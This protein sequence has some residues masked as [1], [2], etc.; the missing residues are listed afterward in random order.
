MDEGVPGSGGASEKRRHERRQEIGFRLVL[1]I[2][3]Q[4]VDERSEGCT[5]RSRYRTPG[6][7]AECRGEV[8]G[9]GFKFVSNAAMGSPGF[10]CGPGKTSSPSDS[11]I[12]KKKRA[13]YAGQVGRLSS[14]GEKS[15]RA[16]RDK[17]DGRRRQGGGRKR[18]SD[19]L[20][21]CESGERRAVPLYKPM[22]IL[23]YIGFG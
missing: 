21:K 13:G 6:K 7:A 19:G 1:Q 22:R 3:R 16:M 9:C 23:L 14:P 12:R 5:I 10:C 17:W 8:D 20:D 18:R 11:A 15:V 2:G 4:P